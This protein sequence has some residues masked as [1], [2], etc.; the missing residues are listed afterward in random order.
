MSLNP[1]GV[2]QYH[3]HWFSA[4]PGHIKKSCQSHNSVL[5]H[6]SILPVHDRGSR[7]SVLSLLSFCQQ[8]EGTALCGDY[9]QPLRDNLHK[10]LSNVYSYT[11]TVH[12][13]ALAL[14]PILVQKQASD[15][16]IP[17]EARTR[18]ESKSSKG[19]QCFSLRCNLAA[20]TTDS[21]NIITFE[22]SVYLLWENDSSSYH[23]F[24]L[25]TKLC[26]LA[27]G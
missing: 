19:L 4:T 3:I 5:A 12:T 7:Y 23:F 27:A 9:K 10:H 14:L 2:S 24:Q 13:I 25:C 15:N 6:P 16:P 26:P 20:Y 21:G 22:Y 18:K 17:C 11:R 8:D 1:R